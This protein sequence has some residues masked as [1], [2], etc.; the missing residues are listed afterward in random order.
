MKARHYKLVS[1]FQIAADIVLTEHNAREARSMEGM[2]PGPT[3]A[4]LR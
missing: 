4:R 3:T 1:G 2:S